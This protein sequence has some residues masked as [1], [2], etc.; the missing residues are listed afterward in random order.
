MILDTRPQAIL[1]YAKELID[2]PAADVDMAE[3]TF[4]Y[5]FDKWFLPEVVGRRVVY[6]GQPNPFNPDDPRAAQWWLDF[7][8]YQSA[9]LRAYFGGAGTRFVAAKPKLDMDSNKPEIKL[10]FDP[11]TGAPF[12]KIETENLL[13]II[14]TEDPVSFSSE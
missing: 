10:E 13:K 2:D 6:F 11:A 7:N 3:A 12:Y 4:Y 1:R 5:R 9:E 8:K 14:P